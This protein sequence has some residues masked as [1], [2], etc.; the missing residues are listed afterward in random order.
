MIKHQREQQMREKVNQEEEPQQPN[1]TVDKSQ[2]QEPMKSSTNSSSPNRSPICRNYGNL[3]SEI[4]GVWTIVF[5]GN[6][7]QLISKVKENYS[8]CKFYSHMQSRNHTDFDMLA[9]VKTAD[10]SPSIEVQELVH[11]SGD[12]FH[13]I[14]EITLE[15]GFGMLATQDQSGGPRFRYFSCNI[16]V[17]SRY[18][19]LA[20]N[21]YV[22]KKSKELTESSHMIISCAKLRRI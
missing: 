15:S 12:L 7:S 1:L 19:I 10:I 9:F 18:L 21:T 4:E 22:F 3:K 2:F 20:V 11:I 16:H 14:T 8:T 13:S 17:F 6:L 5:F